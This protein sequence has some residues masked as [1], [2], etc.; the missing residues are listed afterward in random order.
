MARRG[1]KNVMTNEFYHLVRSLH[2]WMVNNLGY[3][4]SVYTVNYYTEDN[5]AMIGI[6][7]DNKPGGWAGVWVFDGYLI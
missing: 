5:D 3:S 1:S 2:D 7:S 4:S 6:G